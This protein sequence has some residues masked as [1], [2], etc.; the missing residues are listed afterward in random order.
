[1]SLI[2]LPEVYPLPSLTSCSHIASVFPYFITSFFALNHPLFMLVYLGSVLPYIAFR[3]NQRIPVHDER[4]RI[5]Q[6]ALAKH[7]GVEVRIH[8]QLAEDGQH[9][10]CNGGGRGEGG[11]GGTKYGVSVVSIHSLPTARPNIESTFSLHSS[12]WRYTIGFVGGKRASCFLRNEFIAQIGSDA[13]R[14]NNQGHT[15]THAR[16]HTCQHKNS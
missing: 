11:G 3:V 7:H 6:Y 15:H 4:D 16:A 12:R 14:S 9:R 10:H 13:Y 8:I 5:V 1:M 2:S